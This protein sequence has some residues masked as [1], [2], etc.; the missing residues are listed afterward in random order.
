MFH[1]EMKKN[2]HT[3]WLEKKQQQKTPKSYIELWKSQSISMENFEK[4]SEDPSS[5]KIVLL[6]DELGMPR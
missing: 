2:I 3:F 6:P 1:G 4:S 5:G